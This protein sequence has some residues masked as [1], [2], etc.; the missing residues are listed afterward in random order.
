MLRALLLIASLAFAGAA[1][2]QYKW[3]DKDGRVQYG[4]TPPPG[5]KYSPLRRPPPPLSQPEASDKKDD[6]KKGPLT[7]SEK[8]AEFRKRRQEAEQDR[9]KQAKAQQ[10]AEG[11]RENCARAQESL[12]GLEG[13][14]VARTDA[15]GER[16]FLDDAQ[17]AQE[18]VKAR[19]VAQQWCN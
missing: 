16:Y 14:R 18:T 4:D 1:A 2:A 7:A 3:V 6:P 11:K 10:E 17:L 19:Q 5:V 8:D 13:G 12:R 9:Q 15:K